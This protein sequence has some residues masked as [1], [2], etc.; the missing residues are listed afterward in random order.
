MKKTGLILVMMAAMMGVVSVQA[1]NRNFTGLSGANM[2]FSTAGNWDV[3]PVAADGVYVAVTNING[4]ATSAGSRA[5]IDSGFSTQLGTVRIH[6]QTGYGQGMSYAEV[7]SGGLL[8][9]SN[10]NVGNS[11]NPAFD[12]N[13]ILRSGGSIDTAAANSGTFSIGGETPGMVGEM[14][15]E[16]GAA[17]FRE[18]RVE[19]LAYGKMTFQFGSNSVSTLQTARTT[20]G[21]QNTLNGLLLVDLAALTTDGTYTLVNSSSANLLIGGTMRTWLDSIGGSYTNTGNFAN[22]NFQVLN[23]GTK[24]WTL[25]LADGNQDLTLTVIP[26]P[27]TISMLMMAGAGALLIRR[28]SR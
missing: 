18:S 15:V 22:A 4:S 27:T 1:A 11:G 17:L 12:G 28:M 24:K 14:F 20:A 9:A 10:L 6:S 13:L 19:L 3:A 21:V 8:K 23:G 16:A 5:K 26:E 2:N 25:A 7:A